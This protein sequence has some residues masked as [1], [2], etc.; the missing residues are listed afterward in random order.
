M[1]YANLELDSLIDG[2]RAEINDSKTAATYRRIQE[3]VWEG[4]PVIPLYQPKLVL[5]MRP[6]V[7][8]A[9]IPGLQAFNLTDV[10]KTSP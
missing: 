2:A 7:K 8:G 1:Q 6:Q 5:A 4:V 10:V 9:V 3:K